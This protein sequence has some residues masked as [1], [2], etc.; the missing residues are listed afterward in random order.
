M[1]R[2]RS[3][4]PN[5]SNEPTKDRGI[6][7]VTQ[8]ATRRSNTRTRVRKTSTVPIKALRRILENR[9]KIGRRPIVPDA[10]LDVLRR[11]PGREPAP[12]LVRDVDDR[13]PFRRP[14][15]HEH[16][17]PAVEFGDDVLVGESV[18]D[19]RDVADG[20]DRPVEPR[21]ER[22]VR[23]LRAGVA[24]RHGMQDHPPRLR[25]ELAER[26][27][28]GGPLHRIRHLVEGKAV[29]A[30]L[31]FAQLDR[32][33]PVAGPLQRYLGNGRQGQQSRRA[34]P[35]RRAAARSRRP[36]TRRPRAS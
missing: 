8:N 4:V 22:D 2:V 33:L 13:L 31:L 11:L 14:D 21:D 27:V 29:A 30:Q 3:A 19:P 9:S 16:R 18:P 5:R 24:L 17:G 32:Y 35:R 12:D 1:L 26:E 7:T 36:G 6:P 10:D 25:A 20:H 34:A 28:E 23:E 15:P